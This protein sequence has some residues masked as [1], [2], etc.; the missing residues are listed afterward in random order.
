MS[1]WLDGDQMTRFAAAIHDAQ[2]RPDGSVVLGP[3]AVAFIH[4]LIGM[5][6]PARDEDGWFTAYG[7]LMGGLEAIIGPPARPGSPA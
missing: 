3:A 2:Q 6:D 4:E 5:A 7:R 1:G